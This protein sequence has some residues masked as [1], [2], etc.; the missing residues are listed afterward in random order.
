MKTAFDAAP[1]Q[2]D[3]E[4]LEKIFIEN[5]QFEE[6]MYTGET[7]NG[8]RHG[9]GTYCFLDGERYE[10]MFK[11]GIMHGKGTYYESDGGKYVG[12]WKEN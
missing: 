4:T 6:G 5:L 9:Q 10:G 3:S 7:K 1:G 12:M 8:I 11:D 2:I